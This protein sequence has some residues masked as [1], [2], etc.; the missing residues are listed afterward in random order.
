M[1]SDGVEP[2]T[3]DI[4]FEH[5]TLVSCNAES[6]RLRSLVLDNIEPFK[7]ASA[8]NEKKGIVEAI[9]AQISSTSDVNRFEAI[10]EATPLSLG[11][12][13][14]IVLQCGT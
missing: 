8:L 1:N 14:T 3:E 12:S 6:F 7:A 13:W 4:L 9:V 11:M 2:G 10:T 5:V